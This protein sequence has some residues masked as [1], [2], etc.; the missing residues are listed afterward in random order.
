MTSDDKLVVAL[1]GYTKSR[2]STHA[3]LLSTAGFVHWE[4]SDLARRQIAPS[5]GQ[6]GGIEAILKSTADLRRAT[7]D[8]ALAAHLV[9]EI[10]DSA[11]RLHVV[12]GLRAHA[13]WL[14]FRQSFKLFQVIYLHSV[15]ELRYGRLDSDP[16]SIAK[17]LEDY[18][19][20]D[21]A[22]RAEGIRGMAA[23]ADHVIVNDEGYPLSPF[24][25]IVLAIER[26]ALTNDV[27][28]P[29]RTRER[30]LLTIAH[31]NREE[32]TMTGRKGY[33][34]KRLPVVDE[35]VPD[36]EWPDI[37]RIVK[38]RGELANISYDESINYIAYVEFPSDGVP[39]AN[40]FHEE[41]VEHMYL[42]T[43]KVRAF[44]RLANDDAAVVH[45]E[46]LEAGD[47]VTIEPGWVHAYITVEPG[48]AI[49]YSTSGLEIIGKDKVRRPII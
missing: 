6:I 4:M 13:D 16:S 39:R 44:Y 41:K 31:L 46:L 21:R 11:H 33:S 43:G 10:Q 5:D 40:H 47:L 23:M 26:F 3:R 29:W 19:L 22:G 1:A 30:E 32:D 9:S 20:L 15:P 27:S 2:K 49:E 7:G 17:G 14:T 28:I 18:E 34:I 38:T 45:E 48:H 35:S 25:Q 37:A 24:E 36:S 42:V 12:A 8:D